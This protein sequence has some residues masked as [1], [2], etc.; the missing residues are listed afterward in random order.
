MLGVYV[1]V[2]NRSE[3]NTD[4]EILG[5][6]YQTLEQAVGF[7]AK[8][9]PQIIIGCTV[10]DWV[11]FKSGDCYHIIPLYPC[12]ENYCVWWG[13][14]AI[15][16]PNSNTTTYGI[17]PKVSREAPDD[18]EIRDEQGFVTEEKF[19]VCKEAAEEYIQCQEVD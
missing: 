7:L 15:T 16:A 5:S 12:K 19:F 3:L 2:R 4:G 17:F 10:F 18:T 8:T 14:R 9:Y 11:D 13:V 6:C 1:I